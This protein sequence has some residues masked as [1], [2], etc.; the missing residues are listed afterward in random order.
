MVCSFR[1]SIF[2]LWLITAPCQG[3]GD[4]SDDMLLIYFRSNL[5][6]SVLSLVER[7][8]FINIRSYVMRLLGTFLGL[9]CTLIAWYCGTYIDGE[10]HMN[11]M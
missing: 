1:H 6:V 11:I 9:V 3:V 2:G 10:Q 8:V 4:G 5:Q 7:F